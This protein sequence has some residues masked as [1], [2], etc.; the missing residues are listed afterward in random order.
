MLEFESRI[1]CEESQWEGLLSNDKQHKQM[2]LGAP[3]WAGEKI[4]IRFVIGDK[5]RKSS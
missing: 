5:V 2:C 4:H 3:K 1:S